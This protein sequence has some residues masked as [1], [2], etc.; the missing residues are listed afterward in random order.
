MF[1]RVATTTANVAR[2]RA[3]VVA[4]KTVVRNTISKPKT[5]SSVAATPKTPLGDTPLPPGKLFS[6]KH[7]SNKMHSSCRQYHHGGRPRFVG[8]ALVLGSVGYGGYYIGSKNNSGS[9]A[10]STVPSVPENHV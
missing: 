8:K 6:G 10:T 9:V 1:S 2:R 4:S 5:F 3:T 7:P